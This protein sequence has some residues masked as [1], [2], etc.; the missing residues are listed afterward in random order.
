M[1]IS[2]KFEKPSRRNVFRVLIVSA[3]VA[4]L[5]LLIVF[6]PQS[7]PVPQQV[8]KQASFK[9]VYPSDLKVVSSGKDGFSYQT[10]EK[11]IVFKANYQ[12]TNLNVTEQTT[13]DNLANGSGVY[14]QSLGLHPVAQF[15]TSLGPVAVVNFYKTGTLEATG[16]SAILVAGKTMVIANTADANGKLSNDQ[17]KSFF[18]GLKQAK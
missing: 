18:D 4:A 12:K 8:T 7:S 2:L 11:T 14:F 5:L 3:L 1:E 6:R 16:Q 17:W 15:N 9:V 10:S 13:P